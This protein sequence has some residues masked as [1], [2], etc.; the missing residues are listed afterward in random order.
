[1]SCRTV[2]PSKRYGPPIDLVEAARFEVLGLHEFFVG[3]FTGTLEDTDDAFARLE[4][5]LHAQFSMIA[6]SG[7]TLDR[8]AVVASVRAAHSTAGDGFAIEIRDVVARVT[9]EDAVL[10]TYEEWQLDGERVE[11]RRAS[12]AW[13]ARA[14]GAPTRVQWR[15]LHETFRVEPPRADDQGAVP[16]SGG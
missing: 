12:T 3:W 2:G 6:P 1:M 11:S 4:Q 13:F 9:A 15:H 8:A 10:V 7:E 14:A 16:A 5:S